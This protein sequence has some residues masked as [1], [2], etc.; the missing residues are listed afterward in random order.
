M[1]FQDSK[2]I[3]I[4]EECLI[5][6]PE[7]LSAKDGD[8]ICC[9]YSEE[10]PPLLQQTGMAS[11]ITNYYKPVKNRDFIICISMPSSFR[12]PVKIPRFP[13]SNMVNQ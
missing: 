3:K 12:N 10:H 11:K 13:I 9:E 1:F 8:I 7:E 5:D 4:I 2:I 6:N